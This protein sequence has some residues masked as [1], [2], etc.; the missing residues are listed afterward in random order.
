MNQPAD[1]THPSRTAAVHT[2]AADRQQE[3]AM[4]RRRPA[5][6]AAPDQPGTQPGSSSQ[7]LQTAPAHALGV[8]GLGPPQRE[9]ESLEEML[10][11]F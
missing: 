4:G 8:A 10:S 6:V 9:H 11:D 2:G 1:E 3:R 7:L 5:S